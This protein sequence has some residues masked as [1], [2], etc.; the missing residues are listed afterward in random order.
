MSTQYQ[1]NLTTWKT[2][3]P[4]W[5]VRVWNRQDLGRLWQRVMPIPWKNAFQYPVQY[6]D[7]CRCLILYHHGGVYADLDVYPL[8]SLDSLPV[9]QEP[10]CWVGME[11]PLKI[12]RDS[13]TTKVILQ[14]LRGGGV[15]HRSETSVGLPVIRD[16]IPERLPRLANFWMMSTP[17]HQWLADCIQLQLNRRHLPVHRE[18]DIVYTT[19]PDVISEIL[20]GYHTSNWESEILTFTPRRPTAK[21][22]PVKVLANQMMRQYF[23]H[24]CSGS[25]RWNQHRYVV[26]L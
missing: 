12:H 16:G 14:D 25:W 3:H 19:G 8:K 4:T 9:T 13:T 1:T 21:S 5:N 22:A 15:R 2:L 23:K 11:Y 7:V 24:Q 10:T 20:A 26:V 6:A 17:G 18:Y